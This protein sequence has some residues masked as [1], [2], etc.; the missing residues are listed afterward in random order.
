MRSSW[1]LLILLACGDNGDRGD[2]SIA[3]TNEDGTAT[4]VVTLESH[5]GQSATTT[6]RVKNAGNSTTGPIAISFQGEAARDYS[7]DEQLTSCAAHAL[8]PQETCDVA[9]VFRPTA[10]G[11]RDAILVIASE[12]GGTATVDLTGTGTTADLTWNPMGLDFGQ[13]EI[14]TGL[15]TTVWLYN[16]G[17]VAAP[18]DTITTTTPGFGLGGNTCGTVLP[19][20]TSCVVVLLVS[21]AVLGANNGMLDVVSSGQTYSTPLLVHGARRVTVIT[22]N[23][24][25]ATGTVSSSPAGLNCASNSSCT[26]LFETDVLLTAMSGA[27]SGVGSWSV[28]GCGTATTCNIVAAPTPITVTLNFVVAGAGLLDIAF[29]GTSIGSVRVLDGSTVNECTSNCTVPITPGNTIR[30]LPATPSK[31]GGMTGA[32]PVMP[33][34]DFISCSFTAPAGTSNVTVTFDKYPN[35]QWT[36][37]IPVSNDLLFAKLDGSGNVIVASTSAVTK[38]SPIGATIWTQP[39]NVHALAVGPGDGFNIYVVVGGNTIEKLNPDG[40]TQWS[41][42][43]NM[44]FDQAACLEVDCIAI[45]PDGAVA[46][47]G[48]TSVG[49]WSAVGNP[50]WTR[51]VSGSPVA[52][53]IFDR[54]ETLYV[55]ANTAGRRFTPDGIELAQLAQIVPGTKARLAMTS[56]TLRSMFVGGSDPT[57]VRIEGSLDIATGMYTQT[58]NLGGA[59]PSTFGVGGF[60]FAI[61]NNGLSG[62]ADFY[63]LENGTTQQF[64]ATFRINAG[65]LD[66]KV[67]SGLFTDGVTLE[68]AGAIPRAIAYHRDGPSAKFVLA[69][70]WHTFGW[71]QAFSE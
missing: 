22:T 25:I 27:S 32:C 55:V 61:S 54:F 43:L 64:P 56:T 42:P 60:G 4:S 68:A 51:S 5:I 69:G 37:L 24:G 23:M 53:I 59:E 52:S 44:A 14:G 10:G 18:I 41:Q 65:A 50:S 11:D 34:N 30:I 13:M 9:I 21:P 66:R 48:E 8:A 46:V 39:R 40:S 47:R 35:E 2:A 62:D 1:L 31:F 58:S 63:Q 38:L 71:V 29:A 26:A 17:A 20:G 6:V 3:I 19:P 28:A 70:R 57:F 7:F 15:S 12:P 36:S 67:Y 45:A 49:R 16:D 33:D